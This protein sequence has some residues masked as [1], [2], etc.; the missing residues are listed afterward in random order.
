MAS[1]ELGDVGAADYVMPNHRSAA[2]LGL[3]RRLSYSRTRS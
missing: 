2:A 3:A 1:D